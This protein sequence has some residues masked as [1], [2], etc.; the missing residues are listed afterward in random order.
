MQRCD[1]C[2]HRVGVMDR[3]LVCDDC[4]ETFHKGCAITAPPSCGLPPE[5]RESMK[6]LSPALD[7]LEI[8]SSPVNDSK[9]SLTSNGGHSPDKGMSLKANGNGNRIMGSN[10]AGNLGSNGSLRE[11]TSAQ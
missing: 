7:A 10:N 2:R 11:H 9:S 1:L 8:T 6:L 3:H 5:V 4:G